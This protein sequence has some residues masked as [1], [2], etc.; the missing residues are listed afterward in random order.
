MKLMETVVN[1]KND[2]VKMDFG[3]NNDYVLAK[4]KEKNEMYI[5]FR[6]LQ[7]FND[8]LCNAYIGFN[9]PTLRCYKDQGSDNERD[10]TGFTQT[11]NGFKDKFIDLIEIY[12]FWVDLFDSTLLDS[13]PFPLM[14]LSA[15]KAC[16]ADLYI[17]FCSIG[18][19]LCILPGL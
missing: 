17:S 2:E 10:H 15:D 3:N 5:M 9:E 18:I 13:S 12:F 11:Y 7:T 14:G 8:W 19:P 16:M 6:G 1:W 4:N